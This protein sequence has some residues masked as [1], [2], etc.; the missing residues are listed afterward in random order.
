MTSPDPAPE[1]TP[2]SAA[3][4]RGRVADVLRSHRDLSIEGLD[5][6]CSCGRTV[7]PDIEAHQAAEIE[8]VLASTGLYL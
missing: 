3:L 5:T 8:G 1:P 4:R 7:A 2:T 6:L